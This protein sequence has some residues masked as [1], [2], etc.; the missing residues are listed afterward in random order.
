MA[1]YY[2]R[3][4]PCYEAP[5]YIAWSASN[6]SALVRIPAS[7]GISTRA[8]VRCPD[9]ACNPYLALAM[10]LN[11]GLD[12]VRNKL[13]A[14]PSVDVDI[15]EMTSAEKEQAC[16]A[17]LP[18]SLEE[19]IITLKESPIARKTLGEHIFEKYIEG[20]TK[21]WDSYRTAVTDWEINRY[22][23]NY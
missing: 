1:N 2:K 6:R 10:M 13:T 20:K 17:S 16:I 22:I 7:R 19:A 12:G 18:G 23:K 21:E 11:A 4:V 8:E 15:F 3:L 9:P 5:N 14:P